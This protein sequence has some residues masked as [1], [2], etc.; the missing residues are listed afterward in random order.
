MGGRTRVQGY[1]WTISL[2][3]IRTP[4]ANWIPSE[5][6][7]SM[8]VF[9]MYIVSILLDWRLYEGAGLLSR[10]SF[11]QHPPSP[12]TQSCKAVLGVK[13]FL[14]FSYF[15]DRVVEYALRQHWILGEGRGC[16]LIDSVNRLNNRRSLFFY[17]RE[18]RSRGPE[19]S[20]VFLTG[21]NRTNITN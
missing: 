12:Y 20:A 19:I 15:G 16:C 10:E 11:R 17:T 5:H 6:I 8:C 2:P 4:L 14:H 21:H 7:M 13:T 18:R 3:P 9:A 1:C